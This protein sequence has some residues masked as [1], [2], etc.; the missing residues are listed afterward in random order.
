MVLI[1][2]DEDKIHHVTH[3]SL[4]P[5]V[6]CDERIVSP[7]NMEMRACMAMVVLI[8]ATALQSFAQNS[9]RPV[10]P[11]PP[12]ATENSPNFVISKPPEAPTP[13]NQR[14]ELLPPSMSEDRDLRAVELPL[15]GRAVAESEPNPKGHRIGVTRSAPRDLVS[16]GVWDRDNDRGRFWRL[17]VHDTGAVGMR[18]HLRGVDLGNGLLW[19]HN[20]DRKNPQISKVVSGRGDNRGGEIW[21]EVIFGDQMVIEYEPGDDL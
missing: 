13:T 9:S 21:S 18:V 6:V 10:A 20:G 17:V 3:T 12:K 4:C 8:A 1:C 5:V 7:E 14:Y 11:S 15:L 16:R 2:L 19:F